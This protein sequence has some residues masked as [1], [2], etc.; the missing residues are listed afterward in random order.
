MVPIGAM[1]SLVPPKAKYGFVMFGAAV[2]EEGFVVAAAN[3]KQQTSGLPYCA[4]RTV[5]PP[6]IDRLGADPVLPGHLGDRL[7]IRLPLAW[8]ADPDQVFRFPIHTM[9]T[10]DA[11]WPESANRAVLGMVFP[12][13]LFRRKRIGS[14][15]GAQDP[16][17]DDR[18]AQLVIAPVALGAAV[19]VAALPE[20]DGRGEGGFGST[21]R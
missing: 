21:G 9:C 20:S 10:F 7:R 3:V 16:A 12:V 1:Q 17:L 14:E 2:M 13:D 4:E 11:V 18:I 15:H 8:Q 19:E 6:P 5:L